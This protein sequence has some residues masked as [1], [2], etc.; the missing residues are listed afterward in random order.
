MGEPAFITRGSHNAHTP[1]PAASINIIHAFL[2]YDY[3]SAARRAVE[4]TA[5]REECVGLTF[6]F[7]LAWIAIEHNFL[8]V[9]DMPGLDSGIQIFGGLLYPFRVLTFA[10]NI[11]FE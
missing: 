3:P 6:F 11:L 2:N 7:V 10:L 8:L 5:N 1:P 9:C 4:R